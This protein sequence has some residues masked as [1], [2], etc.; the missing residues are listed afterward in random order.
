MVLNLE[1]MV[2]A[3]NLPDIEAQGSNLIKQLVRQGG[4]TSMHIHHLIS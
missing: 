3:P 2:F 4:Q 1:Q